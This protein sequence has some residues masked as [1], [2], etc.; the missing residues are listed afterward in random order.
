MYFLETG[1]GEPFKPREQKKPPPPKQ[2]PR[3]PRKIPAKTVPKGPPDRF[4]E[5]YAYWDL[6]VPF[7]KDFKV[8][9]QET[10][11]AI[12]R[13]VGASDKAR[14]NARVSSEQKNLKAVH[15]RYLSDAPKANFVIVRASLRFRKNDHTD[16][17]WLFI[18]PAPA[19]SLQDSIK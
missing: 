12:A 9:T 10:A 3:P 15:D 13:H 5:L 19:L 14:V 17:D 7:S 2:P 11:K 4:L 16:F 8:F 6:W 18:D 1:L